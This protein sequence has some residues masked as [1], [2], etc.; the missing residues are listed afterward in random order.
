MKRDG[1]RRRRSLREQQEVLERE[2]LE[3]LKL[4]DSGSDDGSTDEQHTEPW[5]VPSLR[6][7]PYE[8]PPGLRVD[9]CAASKDA[10]IMNR[11]RPVPRKGH[12]PSS[13]ESTEDAYPRWKN[14][15]DGSDSPTLGRD[16]WIDPP[17]ISPISPPP[18]HGVSMHES[19]EEFR[20]PS[21]ATVASGLNPSS[22]HSS[23]RSRHT[24]SSTNSS[25]TSMS[26]VAPWTDAEPDL[27]T[28]SHHLQ[29]EM[30]C[31]LKPGEAVWKP[32]VLG[33]LYVSFIFS[34]T[35][36]TDLS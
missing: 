23:G 26:I 4:D 9:T 16:E 30:S 33:N 17:T 6:D 35:T 25:R 1:R 21:T 27:V 8:S 7:S 34:V 18:A 31:D 10:G 2:I 32:E 36:S 5:P 19:W 24:W 13:S 3:K 11:S 28:A 14:E 12:R 22:C 20:R 29:R 15:F